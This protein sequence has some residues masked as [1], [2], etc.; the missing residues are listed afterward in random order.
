WTYIW[1][2]AEGALTAEKYADLTA[3]LFFAGIEQVQ[4]AKANPAPAVAKRTSRAAA[5]AL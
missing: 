1:L 5:K 4:D 2:K 3:D